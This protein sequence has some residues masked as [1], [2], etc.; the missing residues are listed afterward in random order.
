M[1]SVD[2]QAEGAFIFGQGFYLGEEIH[3]APDGEC[4]TKGTWEY[5]PTLA[6]NMPVDFRVE[7]LKDSPYPH[8]VKGAKAVG[9][10]VTPL[11]HLLRCRHNMMPFPSSS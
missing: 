7:F 4:L 6:T 5:K 1:M 10:P 11:L 3:T 2:A 8:G 9:E